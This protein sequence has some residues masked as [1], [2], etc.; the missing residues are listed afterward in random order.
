[1]PD[2]EVIAVCV[3]NS[4]RK[5]LNYYKYPKA[6]EITSNEAK[7]LLY[8]S[9]KLLSEIDEEILDICDVNDIQNEIEESAEIS[10]RISNTKRR[11]DKHTKSA[12]SA[13]VQDHINNMN[14]IVTNSNLTPSTSMEQESIE[15]TTESTNDNLPATIEEN[16][17]NTSL[18]LGNSL[19][20][21]QQSTTT[22]MST[23]PLGHFV[24]SLPK[25]PKLEVPKYGGKVTEWNS[26]WD[27]YD[28]AIHSNPTISKV[29][30]FNYL[31]SLLEGQ[32]ARAI[33]GL[34]LT[35]ANYDAAITILRERLGKT[36]QTIAAQMD[37]I[38][39]IQV[40]MN[41]R[42]SQLRYVYDKI[43]VHVRGLASLGVSSEQYGSMLIPIIMSKLPTEIRLEI[44]RKSTGDVWKIEELLDTIKTEIEAREVSEGCSQV[45][46]RVKNLSHPTPLEY[47]LQ[48]HLRLK[49]KLVNISNVFIAKNFIF[50]H[51][52]TE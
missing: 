22:T 16:E 8:N 32:A 19:P 7:L 42:T 49:T 40:C 26:F 38:L 48:V 50:R 29:N 28:S 13:K 47:P 27:L 9:K 36:Q 11:I 3:Q 15:N 45:N 51:H 33:K 43:S 25:L 37:E 18:N 31:Q 6:K 34:T 14:V 12:K 39:K 52:V 1:V 10:D 20:L 41:G 4:K 24:P 46:N 21:L 44:A 17:E 23:T 30:K 35:N 5:R 2:D